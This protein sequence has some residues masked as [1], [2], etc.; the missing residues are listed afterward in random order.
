MCSSLEKQHTKEHIIVTVVEELDAVG[1]KVCN[2]VAA[3]HLPAGHRQQTQRPRPRPTSDVTVVLWMRKLL[4]F[5][6]GGGGVGEGAGLRGGREEEGGEM[7]GDRQVSVVNDSHLSNPRLGVGHRATAVQALS[8]RHK[9]SDDGSTALT[10]C[11]CT[12]SEIHSWPKK[13]RPRPVAPSRSNQSAS[14][15]FFCLFL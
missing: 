7:T 11:M 4:H 6:I 14:E 15:C 2:S 12:V 8:C 5:V 9:A 3:L 13:T 10:I 1:D